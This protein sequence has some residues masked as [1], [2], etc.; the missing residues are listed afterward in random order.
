MDGSAARDNLAGT[1]TVGNAGDRVA[2]Q[3]GLDALRIAAASMVFLF[4]A[5][6]HD[7]LALGPFG[8]GGHPGVAIFFA[9]SGYLLYRPVVLHGRPSLAT[10]FTKRAVRILPAY[11]FALVGITVLTGASGFLDHPATY[12]LFLQGYDHSTIFTFAGPSWSLAVEVIFYALVPFLGRWSI[13]APLGVLSLAGWVLAGAVLP[14]AFGGADNQLYLLLFPL[15]FWQ[16][17][18]GMALARYQDRIS[19]HRR[20]AVIG[21]IALIVVAL[22]LGA[23][24]PPDLGTYGS[25]ML[26]A[27]G[28]CV[29]IMYGSMAWRPSVRTTSVLAGG[30]SLTYAAYLWHGDLVAWLPTSSLLVQAMVV[31]A[32]A[33]VSYLAIERPSLHTTRRRASSRPVLVPA[34]EG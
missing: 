6:R 31:V 17:A 19:G 33:A 23:G 3:P 22:T 4:H 2:R 9:L 30:A 11:W 25:M 14:S 28:G 8:G 32:I 21:G 24:D 12:L 34:A 15:Q 1:A 29:L 27:V 16:F 10:Y 18:A 20:R 26:A 7:G 13:V 5:S